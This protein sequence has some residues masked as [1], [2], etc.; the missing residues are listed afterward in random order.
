MWICASTYPYIL[1]VGSVTDVART[2]YFCGK[3]QAF[4]CTVIDISCIL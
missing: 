1:G 3:D 4:N 2:M